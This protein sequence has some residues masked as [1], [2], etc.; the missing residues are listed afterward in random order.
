MYD[1]SGNHD[2]DTL[3]AHVK[4]LRNRKKDVCTLATIQ[5]LKRSRRSHHYN[6][7]QCQPISRRRPKHFGTRHL[8]GKCNNVALPC[9]YA[10]LFI[11]KTRIAPK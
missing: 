5:M 4:K 8:A 6:K 10:M 11:I 2:H 9:L 1:I 3:Y 7:R